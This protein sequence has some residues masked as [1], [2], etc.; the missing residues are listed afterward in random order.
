MREGRRGGRREG[1]RGRERGW[2]KGGRC[3]RMRLLP[4]EVGR[5]EGGRGRGL[6]ALTRLGRMVQDLGVDTAM[7][8]GSCGMGPLHTPVASNVLLSYQTEF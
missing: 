8:M 2:R 6:E 4:H 5:R 1:G 7:Q 3:H